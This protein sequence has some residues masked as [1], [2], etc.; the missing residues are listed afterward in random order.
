MNEMIKTLIEVTT[1]FTVARQKKIITDHRVIVDALG[2]DDVDK[3]QGLL[4]YHLEDASDYYSKAVFQI[5]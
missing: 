4:R 2:E 3:A 5:K 1:E